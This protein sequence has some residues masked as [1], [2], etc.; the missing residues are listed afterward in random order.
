MSHHKTS[1]SYWLSLFLTLCL[2]FTT[3]TVASAD[4]VKLSFVF[5]GCNRIQHKDWK[6]IQKDDPSSANLPQLKQTFTDI[7]GL[8]QKPSMLFFTGDL[9]LNLAD[10]DGTTLKGQLDAWADLYKKSPING[11]LRLV[12]FTGNHE[13][14][15]K[16]K[17][18]DDEEVPNKHCGPVFTKWLKKSGF[19]TFANAANGPTAGHPKDDHLVDDQSE[20]TYSFDVGDIHFV[21]IN[22]DTLS[23]VVDPKTKHPYAGWIPYN[24][25]EKDVEAAQAN[26]KTS[27]IFLLG[28]KPIQRHPHHEEDAIVNEGDYKLGNKLVKLFAANDKV[29]AYLC[30]HEHLWQCDTFDKAPKV[31]QVIAGN[32][33][34]QLNSKWKPNGGTFYGF[35]Q[36]NVYASGKVGLTNYKRA[37]PPPP[38]KYFEG[39]P[40]AP[41]P[42]L[43][44]PEQVLFSGS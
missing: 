42:A 44:D 6:I 20:L 16:L 19:D 33:G 24:W 5:L 31:Y 28:H 10:D 25:I 13:V 36:I 23:D 32:G 27:A 4:D 40:V 29:R 30:A 15:R 35:S 7:A 43:P 26:K 14:L 11:K 22:T 38:Q 12:P 18:E 17:E 41:K 3:T 1:A 21:V 37:L 34:S 39:T 2:S 9:V 8:K